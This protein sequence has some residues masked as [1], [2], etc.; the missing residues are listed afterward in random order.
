RFWSSFRDAPQEVTTILEDLG[1]LRDVLQHIAQHEGRNALITVKLLKTC[2]EKVKVLQDIVG[3]LA[4]SLKSKSRPLRTW[5]A[6]KIASNKEKL[7]LFER[8]LAETKTSL[9]L[10]L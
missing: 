2:N 3:P 5:N 9:L 8:S 6:F 10:A 7:S 4:G 1:L